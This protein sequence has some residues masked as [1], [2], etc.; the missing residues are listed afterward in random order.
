MLLLVRRGLVDVDVD[1]NVYVYVYVN[2]GFVLAPYRRRGKERN[3][4]TG[5][6]CA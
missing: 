2:I 4:R 5:T 6:L 3:R 1:V